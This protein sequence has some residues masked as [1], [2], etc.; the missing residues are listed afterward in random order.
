MRS[1]ARKI[2]LP[3]AL[4]FNSTRIRSRKMS[5]LIGK[6]VWLSTGASTMRG[7]V[8]ALAICGVASTLRNI[9]S[10]TATKS[11]DSM[12]VP[13]TK[14]CS[15]GRISV[16]GTPEG[17]LTPLEAQPEMSPA[18]ARATID[19]LYLSCFIKM[20]IVSPLTRPLTLQPGVYSPPDGTAKC[21]HYHDALQTIA[22]QGQMRP[23]SVGR[24]Q[25]PPKGVAPRPQNGFNA[26]G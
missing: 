2:I 17:F 9:L 8:C 18:A 14:P 22:N 13:A 6:R 23:R 24:R 26:R 11:C 25:G 19:K 1:R 12:P 16:T 4:E 7:T 10:V 15:S 21:H 5:L 20:T 3:L